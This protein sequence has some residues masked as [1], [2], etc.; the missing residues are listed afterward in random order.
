M[1][2]GDINLR[3]LGHAGFLIQNSKVIY[4]DPYNISDG[5]PKADLILITHSHHD[6][7]SF[8]DLKKIV[9]EG[10]KIIMT[11]DCQ[12]KIARFDFPI[13]MVIIGP[14]EEILISGIKITALPSY[15]LD[16]DFH[17]M[18]E[19]WVGYLLRIGDVL[20]YHAGD[21]D[22]IPEMKNLTGYNQKGKQLVALLPVGGRFT[23]NAEEAF[24]AAKMIKPT[25]AIPMHWGAIIGA[26]DDAEEF[27]ELCEEKN[28]K[29]EILKKE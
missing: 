2:I 5:L 21:T 12:S 6:H 29:V 15:N 13:K 27:K 18:D 10:T 20:I 8:E 14:N 22:L 24:E 19:G 25:I 28:I 26:R 23:M 3:W 1:K 4:I 11:A 17:L 7:C 9:Q 16:K